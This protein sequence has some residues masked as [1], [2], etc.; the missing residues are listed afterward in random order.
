MPQIEP[1]KGKWDHSGSKPIKITCTYCGS[2]NTRR[3]AFA[4]WDPLQQKWVLGE[5]YDS[6]HCVDCE[7]DARLEDTELTDDEIAKLERSTA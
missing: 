5:V 3:D 6:G 4:E 2:D 7:D 1:D